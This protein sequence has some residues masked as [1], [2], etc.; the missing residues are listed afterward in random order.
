M[1]QNHLLAF[2]KLVPNKIKGKMEKLRHERRR[3]RGGREHWASS[4]KLFGIDEDRGDGLY[5]ME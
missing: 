4:A 2:C 5:F 1:V 3:G